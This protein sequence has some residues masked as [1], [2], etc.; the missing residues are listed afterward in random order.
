MSTGSKQQAIVEFNTARCRA[1]LTRPANATVYAAGDVIS[2]VTT[3]N[4]FEFTN[5]VRRQGNKMSGQISY[6]IINSSANQVTKPYIE[7]W[8]FSADIAEVADNGAFAPTDTE[9]LTCIG[10]IDFPDTNWKV[11]TATAGD[12]GNS[13]CIES[14][15]GI[16]FQSA[17]TSIFGQLVVRN[18]YTPVS[19]EVFTVDLI[20]TQD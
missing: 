17:S 20:I 2:A 16:I 13:L 9:L 8:L 12:G 3:D 1:T 15:P 6:A 7:L 18:A 14:A 11:G 5:A 10:V 4:H 19:G